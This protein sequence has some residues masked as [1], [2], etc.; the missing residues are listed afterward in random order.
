MSGKDWQDF[1]QALGQLH[2]QS[3]FRELIPRRWNGIEISDQQGQTL[4]NF[5]SNDY[6]GLAIEA[7]ATSD[8]LMGAGASALVCGWTEQH[9]LLANQLARFE[10]TERAVLFP[11]GFAACSG[12]IATLCQEGDLIVSDQLNHASLIDGCRLSRAERVVYPHRDVQFVSELLQRDRQRYRR[13]WI[14]TETVFSMDGHVAPLAELVDISE[15]HNAELIVDEAHGTGIL[16]EHMSGAC[17]AFGLKDR[18]AIRLGTL[19][20][21]IGSQGGFVV[22][23]N[24]IADYLIN[25]CRSLIFSTALSPLAVESALRFFATGAG[26][27]NRR[28]RVTRL[29]SSLRSQLGLSCSELEMQVPIVPIV[30]GSDED[31][32]EMSRRL[33]EHRLFVPAIRPPTVPEGTARLRVSLSAA[34]TDE[35]LSRLVDAVR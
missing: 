35:M 2:A 10:Q 21:A 5:G 6:L 11:S 16:G 31:A 22:C 13:V 25:R 29:A 33:V 7:A 30:I 27:L 14:V 26:L 15:R 8:V 12:T 18:I 1:E 9:E 23:P 20:K 17:E 3:R 4:V 34:H 24:V 19:S 28:D 32:M